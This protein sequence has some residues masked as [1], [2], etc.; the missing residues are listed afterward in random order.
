[1]VDTAAHVVGVVAA[2]DTCCSS[3][4]MVADLG[5]VVTL[6]SMAPAA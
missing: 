3:C 6:Q 2:R 5:L 1:V 4:H